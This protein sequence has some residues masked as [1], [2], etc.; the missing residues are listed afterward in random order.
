M[1]NKAITAIPLNSTSRLDM[2]MIRNF[3]VSLGRFAGGRF[4][5]GKRAIDN[6]VKDF[7]IPSNDSA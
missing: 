2:F 3:S 6:M 1:M 7:V 5:A 4:S